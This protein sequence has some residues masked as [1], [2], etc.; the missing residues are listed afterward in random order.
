M[1]CAGQDKTVG[2]KL[3]LSPTLPARHVE[4]SGLFLTL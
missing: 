4:F 2:D 3:H 1:D